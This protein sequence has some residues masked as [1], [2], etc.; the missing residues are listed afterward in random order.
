LIFG[1]FQSFRNS[2]ILSDLNINFLELFGYSTTSEEKMA[3]LVLNG[4]EIEI[5]DGASL[6]EKCEEAG[7]PFACNE[8]VCG[9]CVVEVEEG[10]ENLSEF[11]Q[12]ELDFFGER[13]KE[14]LACQCRIKKGLVKLKF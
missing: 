6:K 8:G 14:R 4:E 11:T 3:K 2:V 10:M 9:V 12:E 13:G 1:Q 5:E 7:V